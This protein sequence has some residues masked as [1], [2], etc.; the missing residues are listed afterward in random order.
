MIV[1]IELTGKH[2]TIDR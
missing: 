2:D 1:F